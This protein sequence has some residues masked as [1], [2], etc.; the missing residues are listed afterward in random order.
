MGELWNPAPEWLAGDRFDAAMNYPL[1][2]A[3]L[4]FVG[5]GRLDGELLATTDEYARTVRPIDGP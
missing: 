1:T 4:S 3:I 5:A 2:E